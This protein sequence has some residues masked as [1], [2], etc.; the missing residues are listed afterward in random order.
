MCGSSF[1]FCGGFGGHLS[2]QGF[3]LSSERFLTQTGLFTQAGFFGGFGFGSQA[4]LFSGVSGFLGQA[5]CL[6]G[7]Q[8]RFFRNTQHLAIVCFL[9]I[10][11]SGLSGGILCRGHINRHLGL[12]GG[13]I[14]SC[15]SQGFGIDLGGQQAAD[16]RTNH[17]QEDE[18]EDAT[19]HTGVHHHLVV[20]IA[21]PWNHG[22]VVLRLKL[23]AHHGD[24]VTTVVVETH[25]AFDQLVQAFNFFGCVRHRCR[26][27]TIRVLFDLGARG[28]RTFVD[29][30]THTNLGDRAHGTF[31]VT[32][33]AVEFVVFGTTGCHLHAFFAHAL[34]GVGVGLRGGLRVGGCWRRVGQRARNTNR[35]TEGVAV[36][37]KQ[38][39]TCFR[40][41]VLCVK[42]FVGDFGLCE[43]QRHA[44]LSRHI[45]FT[46][47]RCQQLNQAGAIEVFHLLLVCEL[48]CSQAQRLL[49]Q[50]VI[51][52]TTEVVHHR[53]VLRREV[54]HAR[55]HQLDDG[56]HVG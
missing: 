43:I 41:F 34:Q 27:R 7:G 35:I 48:L 30:H 28:Q 56:L 14:S 54:R 8:L 38:F 10:G 9:G 42:L 23:G 53:H 24:H 49:G 12:C 40:A 32:H 3:T 50:H 26:R 6:F 44:N 37:H 11:R 36:F 19:H 22:W 4:G 20:L 1:S 25:C 21:P 13:C 39:R 33:S 15:R 5:R 51:H 16:H 2:C 47:D 31:G 29:Q 46:H 45:A 18:Q 55:S 52:Q 17:S